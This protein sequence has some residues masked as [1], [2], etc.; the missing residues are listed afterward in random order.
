MTA[1]DKNMQVFKKLKAAFGGQT[2]IY[3]YWDEARENSIDILS[4]SDHPLK[5]VT[6]Y[7][8]I[9]LSDYD[10]LQNGKVFPTKLE[11]V[12][13][14]F[15]EIDFFANIVSTAAFFIVNDG[16][17]CSPGS[18]LRNV[19]DMYDNSLDIKHI[20]FSPPF[21][22]DKEL[23]CMEYSDRPIAWLLIVPI[24]EQERQYSEKNGADSLEDLFE[25]KQI[26]IFD[27]NRKSAI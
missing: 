6:S 23:A 10:M 26:N 11:L 2:N 25:A 8:T 19:V 27:I 1:S 13:A 21:I 7:G 16:W 20:Y 5:G 12:G 24:T 22:W 3:A 14:C 18:I 15:S 17:L 4:H 9:G